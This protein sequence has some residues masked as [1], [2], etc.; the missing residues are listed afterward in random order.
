MAR[1]IQTGGREAVRQ[2]EPV[3][4]GRR[5]PRDRHHRCAGYSRTS[6]AG[7]SAFCAPAGR[8]RLMRMAPERLRLAHRPRPATT[9]SQC[10]PP[11]C[12]LPEEEGKL[13]PGREA[14]PPRP[15]F[16]SWVVRSGQERCHLEMSGPVAGH[17]AVSSDALP[18]RLHAAMLGPRPMLWAAR[19][20]CRLVQRPAPARAGRRAWTP[21]SNAAALDAR[22][23]PS[24]VAGRGASAEASRE[25]VT[26]RRGP[27]AA[28][29]RRPRRGQGRAAARRI[30]ATRAQ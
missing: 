1:P 10:S 12:P 9:G 21:S 27:G 4:A 7:E 24:R 16:P 3:S 6:A 20:H 29:T 19:A 15:L 26:R 23:R 22:A 18:R 2:C 13:P 14:R 25:E 5:R 8:D 30:A 17:R 28:G 11:P